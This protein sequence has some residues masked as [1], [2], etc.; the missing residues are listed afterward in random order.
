M[1]L[2]VIL[3]SNVHRQA[4]AKARELGYVALPDDVMNA[5]ADVGIAG[6]IQKIWG[7]VE[8]A[9]LNAYNHGMATA[10]DYVQK[11]GDQLKDLASSAAGRAETIRQ[12][13]MARISRYLK[14]VI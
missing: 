11:A 9:L 12:A 1:Q 10:R 5:I 2:T 8:A 4:I 3:S 14:E 6:E 13:I 7:N